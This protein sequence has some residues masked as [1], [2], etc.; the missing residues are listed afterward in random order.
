MNTDTTY[1]QRC[2]EL[3]L[4]G[5]YSSKPNPRV[6]CVIVKDEQVI[7]EG[8]H[9]FAG[10]VHA[11][12]HALE[13]AKSNQVKAKVAG[14]NLYVT[15][16]PCSHHGKTAPCCDAIIAAG[17]SKVVYGMIDPNPAVAGK[18]INKLKAAGIEVVGPLLA[19]KCAELNPGFIKR[20]TTG[21]PYV[22][23][24]MAMSSD[25]RT[26]MANGESK[27]ITGEE[28]RQDVQQWRARSSALITGIETIL[29]DDPSLNVRLEEVEVLQ[30]LRVICDS[31]LRLPTD[32]KTL[33][34]PG[35]ILLVSAI[36]KEFNTAESTITT[37]EQV[38][39]PNNDNQIY[40][41]ALLQYLAKEKECNEVLIEAGST[42]AGAFIKAGLVDEI[43]LYMAPKLLGHKALPLFTIPGLES[44]ADQ[45]NLEYSDVS[46]LGKDCRMRVRVLKSQ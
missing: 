37:L 38:C 3:A 17:I 2:I 25:G 16:E 26:A 21:L 44:M 4:K 1:M 5:E 29:A 36:E 9:Q 19:D 34:T 22:R 40:L 39:L 30:P 8:W 42:L 6:G 27:W 46:L 43:I 10:E 13:K 23:C 41:H 12:V 33:Q 18:G 11:E 20:M 24:K 32:A 28:S 35:E 31:N 7:A 45:I 15:L 14:A